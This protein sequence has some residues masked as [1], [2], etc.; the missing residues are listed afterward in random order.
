MKRTLWY[1]VALL[2]LVVPMGAC[3]EQAPATEQ[4]DSPPQTDA[5]AQGGAQPGDGQEP[6]EAQTPPDD[7]PALQEPPLYSATIEY[8]EPDIIKDNNGPLYTYIRFPQGGDATDDAIADW[9]F[10][11]HR[12]ARAEFAEVIGTDGDATGE[13][14]VNFD[15]WLIDERF[16]GV[17]ERGMFMHSHMAHPRDFVQI[18]NM[19]LSHGAFLGNSEI[20]D[21]AQYGKA[22]SLLRDG[23][24]RQYPD[25]LELL[26]D[27][28]ESW[29]S[30]LVIS[31][32][33]VIV[34]LER[35][36]ERRVGKV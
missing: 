3:S 26:G 18:F 5:P 30:Q 14:N 31:R 23:I 1:I 11:M 34:V 12:G 9:A 17:L 13:V 25:T 2:M 6:G 19:D 20:I 28:D 36:E 8:G 35:S 7:M 16:V 15:S 10:E 22:L 21:P 33:G 32:D 4:P 27:M 24:L 29:L